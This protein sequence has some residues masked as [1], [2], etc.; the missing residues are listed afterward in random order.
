[1]SMLGTKRW[2]GDNESEYCSNCNDQFG[3]FN[4]KHHCRS[5][6]RLLCAQC[7][8][9]WLLIPRSSM[10]SAPSTLDDSTIPQRC[11]NT[12]SRT[13]SGLQ[14]ELR[15]NNSKA[16]A[17]LRFDKDS[18]DRYL[19]IPISRKLETD[20]R[21]AAYTLYNFMAEKHVNEIGL[22]PHELLKNAKGI[23]FVTL[24]KA[25]FL[26]TGRVGTGLVIAR[27]SDGSWSAPSAVMMSGDKI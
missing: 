4:R 22:I 21:K 18:S 12:C 8:S 2:V 26:F 10:I 23:V 20:I 27:L 9:H 1:M 11:C 6:G 17:T 16:N 24:L 3:L 7:C 5:C 14:T 15:Q 19:N 25:G 13:I